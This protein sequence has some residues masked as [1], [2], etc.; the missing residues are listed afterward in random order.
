M[1][2][3]SS[4]CTTV[5]TPAKEAIQA[6]CRIAGGQSALRWTLPYGLSN[7]LDRNRKDHATYVNNV[8]IINNDKRH[9]P[10]KI[11]NLRTFDA[12]A[13]ARCRR[14]LSSILRSSSIWNYGMRFGVRNATYTRS[15]SHKKRFSS[16]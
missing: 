12:A 11:S 1:L 8:S 6:R 4:E 5:A 7:V 16:Q 13:A 14:S 10:H 2:G 15:V 9:A 3:P